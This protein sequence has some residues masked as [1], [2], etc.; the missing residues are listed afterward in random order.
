[1][2]RASSKTPHRSPCLAPCFVEAVIRSGSVLVF[3]CFL[4]V[5]VVVDGEKSMWEKNSFVSLDGDQLLGNLS[6]SK[7][8]VCH[9]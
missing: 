6:E 9:S 8:F 3:A 7:G 4:S 5:V 1:M 2:S